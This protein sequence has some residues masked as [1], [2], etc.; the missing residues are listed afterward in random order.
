VVNCTSIMS[1][2]FNNKHKI[3]HIKV[4]IKIYKHNLHNNNVANESL[5]LVVDPHTRLTFLYKA[6]CTS[7]ILYIYIFFL[8]F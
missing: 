4:K 5:N 6:K 8:E 2:E 1:V 7:E 3:F